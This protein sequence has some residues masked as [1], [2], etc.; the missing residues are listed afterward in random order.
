MAASLIVLLT[1]LEIFIV[2][3][4]VKFKQGKIDNNP[5][6]IILAKEWKILYYAFF[7]W[8]REKVNSDIL[9]QLDKNS[10]YFWLF[11]AL[12]HEQVIELIVFHIYFKKV[13]PS[14]TY[15][16][17]G[18]HIYSIFYIM[19]DYNWVRNTPIRISGNMIEMKI[20]ARRE[21][22]FNISD[23]KSIQKSKLKYDSSGGII[24][25]KAVFHVTAFP[26]VLTKLFGITDELK[27]EI[28]FNK[29]IYYKGYFGLKKQVSKALIYIEES[30]DF[31]S[32]LEMKM[33]DYKKL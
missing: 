13:D 17:S 25:E 30:N 18:L 1:S 7:C 33:E 31:V 12:M 10:T 15:I 26:R 22:S 24:H 23:I 2:Y 3:L 4:F 5:I 6:I 27:H 20:G 8:K 11:I 16:I 29:P 19:G 28:I 9:F 21:L 14:Y 32:I